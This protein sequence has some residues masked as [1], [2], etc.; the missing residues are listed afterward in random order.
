[1]SNVPNPEIDPCQPAVYQIRLKGHLG[2]QWTDWFDGLAITLEDGGDTLI[3]GL[4]ADQS[5]LYGL[6][7]KVRNLGMPLVSVQ[8]VEPGPAEAPAPPGRP[9]RMKDKMKAIVCT[10]YGPPEALQLREVD[11]PDPR[12]NEVLIKVYATTVHFGDVRIRSFNVPRAGW[13]FAR[14]YL[15]LWKPRRPIL[16]MELAGEIETAGKDVKRFKPGDQVFA[17]TLWSGFGAYAE[18]KCLPEALPA[19]AIKPANLT[20]EQAAAI[21]AGGIATLRV[22][23][24]ANIHPGQKVLVYGAS[25]SVGTYAV[26]LAR[27]YGAEVTGVC[28]SGNVALVS[29]LGAARVIDYTRQDFTQSAETYDV[30]FDAVDKLPASRARRSLNKT[31]IYLNITKGPHPEEAGD[32]AFLKDLAEAGKLIPV[33]DRCYPLEQIVE[34]HRYVEKGHKSG[35]V[36]ITVCPSSEESRNG[37][38]SDGNK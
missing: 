30:I 27:Y 21:P 31:G 37:P 24:N 3:T 7:K 17:C 26:Q 23:R 12:D 8:R 10:K 9:V 22:L 13:L 11:K 28:S 34:A 32:L 25:G 38:F 33:I 1:M 18:Y 20:Y 14:L 6:L 4:V 19:L 5:A 16:G 29:S 36:A 2:P 15:G 35:N